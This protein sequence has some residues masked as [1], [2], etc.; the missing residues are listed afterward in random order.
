TVGNGPGA[1]PHARGDPRSPAADGAAAPGGA[2][3]P[4]GRVRADGGRAG[5]H[6]GGASVSVRVGLPR[7]GARR[8]RAGRRGRG[9]RRQSR[10]RRRVE[11]T[12]PD[13]DPPGVGDRWSRGDGLHALGA[14]PPVRR[15][16]RRGHV[17]DGLHDGLGHAADLDSTGG[18][19]VT[20][21]TR[22][23]YLAG[24]AVKTIRGRGLACPSCG[25]TESTLAARKYLVT[26]LR[27][28]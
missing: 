8:A 24:S 16:R 20:A 28:C 2:R 25:S 14:A 17:A 3:G 15:G 18:T 27:R 19:I 5:G 22:I 7:G 23:S 13:A 9:Q 1:V 11:G 6:A 12:G 4:R 10:A 26:A 21:A